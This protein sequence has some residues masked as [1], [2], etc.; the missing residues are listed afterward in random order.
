MNEN[1]I[2]ISDD[3]DEVDDGQNKEKMFKIAYE[4]NKETKATEKK[5]TDSDDECLIVQEVFNNQDN[6][7]ITTSK[8]DIEQRLFEQSDETDEEGDINDTVEITS[9]SDSE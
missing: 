9:S 3:E 4:I 5:E 2:E 1:I 6:I 8:N 7:T